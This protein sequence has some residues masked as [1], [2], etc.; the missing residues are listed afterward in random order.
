MCPQCRTPTTT[1]TTITTNRIGVQQMQHPP[2]HII[3][4]GGVLVRLLVVSYD[5][6][7][8]HEAGQITGCC[9][10]NVHIQ[11]TT[12][13]FQTLALWLLHRLVVVAAVAGVAVVVVVVQCAL[14]C[15]CHS[16]CHWIVDVQRKCN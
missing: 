7:F 8:P 16:Y 14:G 3:L 10:R 5:G 4:K 12:V 13:L 2:S 1:I 6:S 9:C 11:V 15:C